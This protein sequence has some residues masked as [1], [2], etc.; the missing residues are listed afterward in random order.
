M[1]IERGELQ[2]NHPDCEIEW[3]EFE[4]GRIVGNS[5]DLSAFGSY[6]EIDVTLT[7]KYYEEDILHHE[8]EITIRDMPIDSISHQVKVR[9]IFLEPA[10]IMLVAEA[11]ALAWFSHM[12]S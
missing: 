9:G 11:M 8:W 1:F 3:G 6:I 12:I 7:E 10:E 5:C 2:I 4:E